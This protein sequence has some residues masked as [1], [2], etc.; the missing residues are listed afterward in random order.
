MTRV[1]GAV[2]RAP[3]PP[4]S[5]QPGDGAAAAGHSASAS[6]PGVGRRWTAGAIYSGIT[7]TAGAVGEPHLT[8]ILVVDG[9]FRNILLDGA[10]VGDAMSRNTRHAEWMAIKL[11]DPL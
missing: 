4:I 6:N 10:N 5:G 7:V 9:A 2:L 11:G 3:P 1:V 8:S